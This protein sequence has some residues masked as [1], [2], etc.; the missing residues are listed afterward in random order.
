MIY[1]KFLKKEDLIGISALSSGCELVIPELKRAT[2]HLK[3]EFNVTLTPNVYGK[4]IVSSS[5]ER[6]IKELKEL[7][8]E[9]IKMLLVARGGDFLYE[10]LD[11]IPYEEIVKRKIFVGGHSDPSTLLYILTTKYD[12]STVYGMNAKS[13]DDI[14]LLDYQK[15]YLEIIKGN[16]ITQ[17]SFGDRNTL[18]LNGDFNDNGVIIGGCLDV[19]RFLI[20]T[21]LDNTLNFIEKYK[22]KKIIWYFDIFS[23]DSMETYLTLLQLDKIGWFKYTDTI[24][25]GSI[26]SPKEECNLSYNEAYKSVFKDKNIVVDANIGHIRPTF[27]IL[28]GSLVK[29]TSK[30]NEI[31]LETELL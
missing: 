8:Q 13:F 26:L 11:D 1:P 7:L 23:M 30:K 31:V 18:S 25:F 20:G 4:E 27:T 28:N 9:D 10:T 17:K 15:N 3:E 21:N 6:R 19:L 14:E 24:L 5:K 12:L 2:N 22:D 16:L 29:I